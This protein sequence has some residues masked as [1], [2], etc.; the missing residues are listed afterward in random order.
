MDQDRAKND[1]Q[2]KRTSAC[3]KSHKPNY[4][5]AAIDH[6]AQRAEHIARQIYPKQSLHL[7]EN[8]YFTNSTFTISTFIVPVRSH[9]PGL[10]H[11]TLVCEDM[12]LNP[13]S[14]HSFKSSFR[15]FGTFND[16]MLI[17]RFDRN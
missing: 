5:Q 2:C 16:M 17:I 8:I 10:C 15:T 11:L 9:N 13:W 12:K 14:L 7:F 3:I 1:I 4:C 6:F